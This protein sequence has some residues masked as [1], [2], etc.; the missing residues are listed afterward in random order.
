M[1]LNFDAKN[2]TFEKWLLILFFLISLGLFIK[3]MWFSNK[4]PYSKED[5]QKIELQLKE[6]AALRE[7]SEGRVT[8]YK[9]SIDIL[10]K[11]DEL[12][13]TRIWNLER[14]IIKLKNK[15]EKEIGIAGGESAIDVV[16]RFTNSTESDSIVSDTI[17]N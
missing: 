17:N 9:D 13:K 10:K 14:G 1:K 15:Y 7:S 5:Y 3:V 4:N 8:L 2:F 12:A 16:K 11:E 6:E